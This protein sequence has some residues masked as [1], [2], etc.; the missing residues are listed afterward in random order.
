VR[1]L[2][3]LTNLVAELVLVQNRILQF[4]NSVNNNGLPA[5]SQ[6]LNLGSTE[7]QEGV[8][9]IRLQPIESIGAKF[10]CT[11]RDLATACG[12]QVRI[13]ME[14]R[15][16]ESDETIVEAIK[17]P[18]TH[19]VRNAVDHGVEK[20]EIR[21]ASGKPVEGK[22]LLGRISPRRQGKYRDHK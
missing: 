20:P 19:M 18:L 22:I 17:D 21:R 1:L 13:A 6:R 4:T 3:K 8:I 11:A 2:D 5:A 12:K 10:P 14:G 7:L 15:E 16:T 9:K